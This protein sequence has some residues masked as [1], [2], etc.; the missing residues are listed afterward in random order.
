MCMRLACRCAM[1]DAVGRGGRASRGLEG[2]ETDLDSRSRLMF[3]RRYG[4]G[5]V[6][7]ESDM[8]SLNP[9]L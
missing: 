4:D 3:V 9:W 5:P 6:I 8:A 2:L 7:P 1:R